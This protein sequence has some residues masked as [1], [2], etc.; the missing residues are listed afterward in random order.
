MQQ[1]GKSINT[2]PKE[3]EQ[4]IGAQMQMSI[5]KLPRYDMNWASETKI[6]R[7]SEVM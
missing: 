1:S 5:V 4:L 3:I 2:T 7:V 6:P